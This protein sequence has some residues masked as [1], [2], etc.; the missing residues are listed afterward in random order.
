[1]KKWPSSAMLRRSSVLLSV[2]AA[3][4]C[5]GP[6]RA[7]ADE[8][9]S[10]V[11]HIEA[12]YQVHRQH[13]FILGVAGMVVKVWHVAGVKS[14]KI[15]LFEDQHFINT[16]NDADLDD[17]VQRAGNHGWRPM[18]RSYS[19]RTGEHTFIYARESSKHSGKNEDLQLLVVNVE[20]NEAVVVQVKV[21]PEKMMQVL[22]GEGDGIFSTGTRRHRQRNA[23]PAENLKTEAEIGGLADQNWDRACV[24]FPEDQPDLF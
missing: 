8:F 13:R 12:R 24:F 6:D 18:V 17:I 15:A 2:L 20:P 23:R 16:A 1:M 3:M 21:N 7:Y 22:N 4:V 9:G 14:L 11:H 5:L 10:I 19:N